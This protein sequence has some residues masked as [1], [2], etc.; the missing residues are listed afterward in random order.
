M[1][2]ETFQQAIDRGFNPSEYQ[3]LPVPEGQWTGRL[4]AKIWGKSMSLVC[5]FTS[6]TGKKIKLS[7][8]RVKRGEGAGQWYTAQDGLIDVRQ[9]DVEVGQRYDLVTGLNGQGKPAWKSI[10]C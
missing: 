3:F 9:P 4:D 1:N 6:E 10:A 7:A 2:T 8:F 5:Y